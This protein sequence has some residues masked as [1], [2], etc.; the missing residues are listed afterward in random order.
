MQELTRVQKIQ[1]A[2]KRCL[3][4]GEYTIPNTLEEFSIIKVESTE[5]NQ[6]YDESNISLDETELDR[7]KSCVAKCR[8]WVKRKIDEDCYEEVLVPFE[9]VSFSVEFVNNVFV[10]TNDVLLKI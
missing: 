7:C 4:S 10:V 1:K 9:N 5:I 2:L 8:V 3:E 6:C